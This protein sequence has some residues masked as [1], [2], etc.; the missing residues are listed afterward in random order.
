MEPVSGVE[1]LMGMYVAIAAL[2]TTVFKT[3]AHIMIIK[4]GINRLENVVVDD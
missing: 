4:K 3:V 2:D 1:G